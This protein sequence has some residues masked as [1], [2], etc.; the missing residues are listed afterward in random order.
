MQSFQCAS[1]PIRHLL[2]RQF[3]S[4]GQ[5]DCLFRVGEPQIYKYTAIPSGARFSTLESKPTQQQ[6]GHGCKDKDP[7]QVAEEEI[8]RLQAH[9]R[10]HFQ[11]ANYT[12]ALS[13]SETVLQKSLELFAPSQPN[14]PAIASAHN[15]IGLMYK[16]MGN[17][18]L[19]L[20]QYQLALQIYADIVGKDHASYAAALNNIGNLY[21]AQAIQ[22][23]TQESDDEE[24]NAI[25]TKNTDNL[26][27]ALL[28]SIYLNR[29]ALECFH[30]AYQIRNVELGPQHVHTVTSQSNLGG[31]L[32]A[33]IVQE[34]TYKRMQAMKKV[35]TADKEQPSTDSPPILDETK[36][37][38]FMI[39]SNDPTPTSPWDLAEVHLRSAFRTAVQNPR[40]RIVLDVNPT[41]TQQSNTPSLLP[42]KD[43]SKGKKER[44]KDV[45]E[46][47]SML[48]QRTADMEEEEEEE[49]EN[50]TFGDFTI[51]TAS[52]AAAAQNLAVFLKTKADFE[53]NN[54]TQTA[55]LNHM[56][57]YY[58]QAKTLYL[59]SLR[60]RK[61]VLGDSHPD[62]I[63]TK[64]SLA[65]LLDVLGDVDGAKL[66]REEIVDA[67][68]V[69]EK[70]E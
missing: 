29:L 6:R 13:V 1:V 21:R 30:Q 38:S 55:L 68:H 28:P 60:V 57:E 51:Q 46:H 63:A 48:R 36:Y 47:K 9:I 37:S 34:E 50:G 11:H 64:F 43:R 67:Y 12:A 27:Q 7:Q 26:Q 35:M 22:T 24:S 23:I 15:N 16:M 44:R 53:K 14:H 40:G 52:A 25:D 61:M 17:Y 4:H 2:A 49:K 42:K 62:T 45:K 5:L 58:A 20:K 32:A 70:N 10:T 69:L 41:N 33:L 19:A 31:T 65:E 3:R 8:V 66:L 18:D 54:S 56:E 59:G 39:A